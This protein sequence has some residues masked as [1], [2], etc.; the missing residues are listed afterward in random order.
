MS[1]LP[2]C[3]LVAGVGVL[4]HLFYF[5]IGEH[6]IPSPTYVKL[7]LTAPLVLFVLLYILREQTVWQ[8]SITTTALYWS[9]MGGVFSSVTLY[10]AF[11]HPLQAYSGPFLARVSQFYLPF[12]VSERANSA[13]FINSLH[14]KY[15]DY[16]RLGPNLLSV[17]DPDMVEIVYGPGSRFTKGQW[18]DV[19][20]VR[21]STECPRL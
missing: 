15:G 1:L 18:Y 4:S 17:S 21:P 10:R 16:F 12:N 2:L 20:K 3:S 9:F 19:S 7:A 13:W 8:S 11:F 5:R 6:L 14:Q